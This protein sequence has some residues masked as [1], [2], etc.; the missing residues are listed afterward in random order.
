MFKAKPRKVYRLR[1]HAG[2]EIVAIYHTKGQTEPKKVKVN[3]GGLVVAMSPSALES[4]FKVIEGKINSYDGVYSNVTPIEN[5]LD[6]SGLLY[7]EN[8]VST[9]R[10]KKKSLRTKVTA[11]IRPKKDELVD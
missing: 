2:R 10:R 11:K 3:A 9:A 4:N 5:A 7:D 6:Y 1:T 8:D